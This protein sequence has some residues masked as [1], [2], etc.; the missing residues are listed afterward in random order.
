M[1]TKILVAGNDKKYLER[2]A[3]IWVILL[4]HLTPIWKVHISTHFYPKNKWMQY[5]CLF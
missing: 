5:V 1:T 4:L 2:L 3:V